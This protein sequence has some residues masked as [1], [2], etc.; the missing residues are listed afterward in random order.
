M[1]HEVCCICIL[2]ISDLDDV[3]TF[4]ESDLWTES[5][6]GNFRTGCILRDENARSRAHDFEHAPTRNCGCEE[7]L[8]ESPRKNERKFI[9]ENSIH[10]ERAKELYLR[11]MRWIAAHNRAR[12]IFEMTFDDLS[13]LENRRARLRTLACYCHAIISYFD[14]K[15]YPNDRHERFARNSDGILS[16]AFRRR[17]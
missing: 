3:R 4:L 14:R 12:F 6:R 2:L 8:R 9:H 11:T 13:L 7:C 1:L 17:F 10:R 16:F 5:S 15:T